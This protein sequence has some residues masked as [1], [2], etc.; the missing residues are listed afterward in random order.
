MGFE[1]GVEGLRG[2]GQGAEGAWGVGDL[3]DNLEE[4]FGR[5]SC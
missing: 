3:R 4:E 1:E 2:L 5:E